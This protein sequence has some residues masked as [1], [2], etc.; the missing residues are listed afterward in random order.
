MAKWSLLRN[1][2]IDGFWHEK[3]C[4]QFVSQLRHLWP[5]GVRAHRASREHR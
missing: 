1:T 2:R 5:A 3:E 4:R